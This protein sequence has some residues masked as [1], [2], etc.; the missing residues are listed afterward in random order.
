MLATKEQVSASSYRP[1]ETDLLRISK[2]SLMTFQK[3]PRQFYWNYVADIPRAP[4]TDAMIRG[5]H[6]HTI[7]EEGL[8]GGV[9]A[10]YDKSDE[11]GYSDDVGV[12]AL[13]ELLHGIARD[14]GDLDVVECE[15]KH[16]IFEKYNDNKIVWVAIID[17]VL[18]HPDG[19]LI[20]VELKTGNMNSGKLGRTRKELAFYRRV[21]NLHPKY[22]AETVSHFLYVSP[23]YVVPDIYSQDRLFDELNKKGKKMWVGSEYGVA[24]M[25]PTTIRSHNAFL[26]SLNKSITQLTEGE[27]PMKWNDYFCPT[28]C[29]YNLACEEELSG[30]SA[31]LF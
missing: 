15:V 13:S 6:I 9:T 19:G 29:D 27:Y 21:L 3:C 24:I 22:E 18:R 1:G 10:M 11:L 12:F 7:M 23:D 14:L 26:K 30:F 16:Q 5:S 25:E 4:P 20:L 31:P 2:S 8:L 17:G 28:W